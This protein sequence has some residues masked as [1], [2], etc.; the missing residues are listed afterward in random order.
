[1]ILFYLALPGD[2]FVHSFGARTKAIART[3]NAEGALSFKSEKAAENWLNK[4]KAKV[5]LNQLKDA[6]VVALGE[7]DEPVD[8]TSIEAAPAGE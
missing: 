8:E 2:R 7:V 1:M 5:I 3:T 4:Y 6:Q